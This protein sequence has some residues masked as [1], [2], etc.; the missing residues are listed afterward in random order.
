MQI[1]MASHIFLMSNSFPGK[2]LHLRR[3]VVIGIA[4]FHLSNAGV[5]END[6]PGRLVE[7]HLKKYQSL[8]NISRR[9]NHHQVL[10][11]WF[12]W[13]KKNCEWDGMLTLLSVVM[14]MM[15]V[16]ITMVLVVCSPMQC[17]A[18]NGEGGTLP[19][20]NLHLIQV[21]SSN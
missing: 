13:G 19:A 16:V 12:G 4:K 6:P 20:T 3:N 18:G 11:F 15:M 5:V 1:E 9:I 14:M 7:D 8:K 10:L 17:S 2:V 21:G